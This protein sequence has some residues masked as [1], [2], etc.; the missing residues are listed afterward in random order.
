MTLKDWWGENGWFWLTTL[1]M[2]IIGILVIVSLV[3][4]VPPPRKHQP[5][6]INVTIK[7]QP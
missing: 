7:V 4:F 6:C 5:E 3:A 1:A 2:L